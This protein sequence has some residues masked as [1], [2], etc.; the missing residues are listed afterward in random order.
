MLPTR[1]GVAK[2]ALREG[3]PRRLAIEC[4]RGLVNVTIN[5]TVM[6]VRALREPEHSAGT[7]AEVAKIAKNF[8]TVIHWIIAGVR[9][10]VEVAS[11]PKASVRRKATAAP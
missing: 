3:I 9:T 5:H 2:A 10:D 11:P 8:R 1:I 6:E 4:C 7:A